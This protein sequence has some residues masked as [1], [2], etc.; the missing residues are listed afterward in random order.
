MHQPSGFIFIIAAIYWIGGG[1]TI[2]AILISNSHK[3]VSSSITGD[4]FKVTT[5]ESHI[6]ILFNVDFW[7][8]T[9]KTLPV[10]TGNQ[11]AAFLQEKNKAYATK[12]RPELNNRHYLV[13]GMRIIYC[14]N[15]LKRS[16]STAT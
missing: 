15:K 5:R 10:F 12:S 16:K 7:R 2:A 9:F 1:L 4:T 6:Q 8:P 13:W 14:A 11:A 3:S